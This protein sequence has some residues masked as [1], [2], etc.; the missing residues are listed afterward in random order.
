VR[1]PALGLRGLRAAVLRRCVYPM[2]VVGRACGRKEPFSWPGRC[3]ELVDTSLMYLHDG[4]CWA[5]L[6]SS[7]RERFATGGHGRVGA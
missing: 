3:N 4:R 7:K 5:Q 2:G 6:P 1:G